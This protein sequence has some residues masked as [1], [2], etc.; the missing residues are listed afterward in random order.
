M[1]SKNRP[2]AGEGYD[3]I[4]H[5]PVPEADPD[6]VE[7]LRKAQVLALLEGGF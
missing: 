2:A 3:A 4:D 5:G 7:A 1:A 6:E